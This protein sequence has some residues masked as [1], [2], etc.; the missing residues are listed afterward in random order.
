MVK[1]NPIFCITKKITQ[2]D[3]GRIIIKIIFNMHKRQLVFFMLA[4]Y[5][6]WITLP[7]ISCFVSNFAWYHGRSIPSNVAECLVQV[8]V[9]VSTII[10]SACGK[11]IICRRLHFPNDVLPLFDEQME[12]EYILLWGL[13]FFYIEIL[14]IYLNYVVRNLLIY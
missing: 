8:S 1:R 4:L 12:C 7:R 5:N 6:K 3:D 9:A 11:G 13:R 2:N 10:L 14:D